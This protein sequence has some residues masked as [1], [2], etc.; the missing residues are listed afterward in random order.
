MERMCRLGS[1]TPDLW[2]NEAVGSPISTE[3]MLQA[4]QRALDALTD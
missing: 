4:A 3:P 1:I 2:M